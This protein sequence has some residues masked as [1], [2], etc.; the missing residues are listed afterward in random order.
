MPRPVDDGSFQCDDLRTA[1]Y[2]RG[3][4]VPQVVCDS[5]EL[6]SEVEGPLCPFARS[7][8][9]NDAEN[10][11]SIPG[12]GDEDLANHGKTILEKNDKWK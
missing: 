10:G 4:R 1:Q 2:R 3:A 11:G 12:G 7:Q 8:K 6:L 5:A 9:S